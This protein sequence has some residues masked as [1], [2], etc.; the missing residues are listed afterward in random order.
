MPR[1]IRSKARLL[2]IEVLERR[3]VLTPFAETIEAEFEVEEASQFGEGDAFVK[4]KGYGD[5]EPIFLGLE[6]DTDSGKAGLFARNTGI[7]S[8]INS[9]LPSTNSLSPV[10]VGGFVYRTLDEY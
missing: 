1:G 6:F 3:W 5:D 9:L 2:G 8:Q 4:S 10:S 7:D